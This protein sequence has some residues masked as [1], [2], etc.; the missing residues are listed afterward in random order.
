M[1]HWHLSIWWPLNETLVQGKT[2]L[3]IVECG[4]CSVIRSVTVGLHCNKLPEQL[5][6]QNR[7]RKIRMFNF[8]LPR[9]PLS[10]NVLS[11]VCLK[12]STNTCIC[13]C[14]CAELLAVGTQGPHVQNW[15]QAIPKA[16]ESSW[17]MRRSFLTSAHFPFYTFTSFRAPLERSKNNMEGKRNYNTSDEKQV[18]S[19]EREG[20]ISDWN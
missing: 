20:E 7:T 19:V 6:M 17:R 8:Q 14:A 9:Q 11:F 1:F 5:W 12:Q 16:E 10:H 4:M 15:T 13:V 18:F 3:V 2:N